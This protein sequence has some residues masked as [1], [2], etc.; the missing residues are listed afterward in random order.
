LIP[1][2]KKH[3]AP[4]VLKKVGLSESTKTL[5]SHFRFFEGTFERYQKAKA[6]TGGG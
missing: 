1:V 6:T 2:E 4:Y 5:R 3:P